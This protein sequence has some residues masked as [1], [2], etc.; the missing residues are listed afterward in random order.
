MDLETI[1]W[2]VMGWLAMAVTVALLLGGILNRVNGTT[3]EA[4][5]DAVAEHPGRESS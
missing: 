4:E 3:G 5:F 2:F 1:A